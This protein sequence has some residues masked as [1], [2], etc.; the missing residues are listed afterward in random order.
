MA[1]EAL[2]YGTLLEYFI[3]LEELN[4]AAQKYMSISHYQQFLGFPENY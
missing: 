3:T 1:Q 2:E 4:A